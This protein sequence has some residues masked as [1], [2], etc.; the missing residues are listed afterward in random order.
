MPLHNL[1]S[2]VEGKRLVHLSDLHVSESISHH[3]LA[4]AVAQAAELQPDIAVVTGDLMTSRALEQVQPTVEILKQLNPNQTAVYAVPGN[5]DYGAHGA[6]PEQ[7]DTLAS[8]MERAG[9]RMLRN[10]LSEYEGLQIVGFDEVF[11]RRFRPTEALW[12]FDTM[13]EGIALTHNPDTVDLP[14]WAGYSG[15]V[16]AGHTHGGQCRLP[17]FGAPI[18]PIR[19]RRYTAGE[20]SLYDGR[21][22]YVNRGLGYLRQVRFCCSPEITV[23]TLKRLVV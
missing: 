19:N 8:Q 20:V 18:V 13:R 17:Y 2:S 14:G 23:F 15:W 12:K 7:A 4:R 3:Y 9:M 16:L 5:H 22:L 21:R 6:H 1:P 10:E 11:A